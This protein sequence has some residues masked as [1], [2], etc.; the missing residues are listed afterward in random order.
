MTT[1]FRTR[2]PIRGLLPAALGALLAF[3]AASALLRAQQPP[4]GVQPPV[5][6]PTGGGPIVPAAPATQP[7][8]DTVIL[9]VGDEK[10]TYREFD[11][12]VESL[13]PSDQQMARGQFRRAW[14]ESYAN[15]KLLAREAAR[16]K[17]DQTPEAQLRLAAARE[18]VLANAMV[19]NAQEGLDDATLRKYFDE[20]R[21]QLERV[22]ARHI[23]IRAKDSK[24][25]LR[26]GQKDLTDAEA[27]AKAEQVVARLKAGEDFAKVARA[28]SDDLGSA[29]EGGDLGSFTRDRMVPAF[30][31]AAFALKENE[32][33][34][35]VRTPFGY[36]VIQ[37]TGRYDT[38]EKLADL[39]R[40]Q[41]A[42]QRTNTLVRE[43]RGQTRVTLNEQVLGPPVPG[44][45]D[46]ALGGFDVPGTQP[47]VPLPTR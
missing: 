12:F 1:T 7:K 33:S 29:E 8:P 25:P 30:S 45:G 47:A 22:S 2:L 41:L 17:L 24:V 46:P 15:M 39:I 21:P 23:L 3:P 40:Q 37:N 9:T 36:H 34:G 38:F 14:A 5:V 27:K 11:L 32:V 42:P 16:R 44:A 20:Q 4:P 19:V 31:Q 35:P 6:L 18:Q 13:H 10:V 43:L 28:E 26:P